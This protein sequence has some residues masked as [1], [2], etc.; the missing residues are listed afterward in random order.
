MKI[1]KSLILSDND[2]EEFMIPANSFIP[3]RSV[4]FTEFIFVRSHE[5]MVKIA[6]KDIYYIE[7]ERNYCRIYSKDKE[8]MLVMT[9]KALNEKL[10]QESFARVHRSYIVNIEH[11]DEIALTHVAVARKAIPFSKT[12]RNDLL[13]RLQII[14]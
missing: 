7:A 2:S 4:V 14:R 9:L 1:T 11:V 8:Y 6:K 12:Y 5:K 10:P 3:E 13:S